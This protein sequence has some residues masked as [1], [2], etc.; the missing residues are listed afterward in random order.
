M[1]T[2]MAS[3]QVGV[4]QPGG[5]TASA[6]R[7]TALDE[8]LALPQ[9]VLDMLPSAVYACDAEGLIVRFNA[10]AVELWGR[11]PLVGDTEPRFCG[12]LQL[13]LPSGAVLEHAATPMAEVLRTGLPARD[14]EV[15]IERPDGTRVTVLVNI[16]PIVGHGGQL[17]GAINCFQDI[18]ERKATVEALRLSEQRFRDF[19]AAASDWFWETDAEHRF[20]WFSSNVESLVGIP[21]EWH[22]GKTRLELMAATTDPATVEAHRRLLEA[23]EPFRDFQ[24][25]RRGPSGDTWL[26]VSGMPVFDGAG[27]FQG[28]RGVGSD[29]SEKKR[30]EEHR[31]LLVA[32]LS[33]RV[34]NTLAVVQAFATQTGARITTVPEFLEIFRGRLRA[35]ATGHTLVTEAKWGAASFVDL[36]R[37]ALEPY[38]GDGRLHLDIEDVIL[39]PELALTLTLAFHELA[40]NSCKF[41]ALSATA[42]RVTLTARRVSG[43]SGDEL[44]VTWCEQGGPSVEPPEQP[45]FGTKLLVR[46]LEYQHDGQ[47]ELDWREEGLVYRVTVPLAK[48]PGR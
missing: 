7:G 18:S 9:R 17:A 41:G 8:L 31:D 20:T 23:R 6:W 48:A 1:G 14:Q 43:E 47:A 40:T 34:N 42:G 46:A 10:R 21:R 13:Y 36:T 25:L 35:L 4:G 15:V 16:D 32:E 22:Y 38:L 11:A 27:R 45:G 19:A 30:A 5:I 28:Y 2:M 3:E 26:S 29:I 39:M 24:Y 37:V 33:H 44:Q 12:S